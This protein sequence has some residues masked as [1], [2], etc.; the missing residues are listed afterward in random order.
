MV[1]GGVLHT[2]FE[3]TQVQDR[4]PPSELDVDGPVGAARPN[5][6]VC[7][8]IFHTSVISTFELTNLCE[9]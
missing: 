3:G 9:P 8:A 7:L 5:Q 2:G 1:V 4:F 6:K